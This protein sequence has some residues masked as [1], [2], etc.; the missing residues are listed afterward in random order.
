MSLPVHQVRKS[1][2]RPAELGMQPD[3]EVM[4]RNLRG[5]AHLKPAEIMGSFPIEAEGMGELLIHSLHDLAHPSHPASESL[6]VYLAPLLAS[7]GAGLYTAIQGTHVGT[8]FP[9]DFA[10]VAAPASRHHTVV[11]RAY[12]GWARFLGDHSSPHRLRTPGFRGNHDAWL[13]WPI[14]RLFRDT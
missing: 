5:Q 12:Q 6:C 8:L 3:A 9:R 2:M 1:Q 13:G 7:Q 14:A 10:I 4:Q 11:K